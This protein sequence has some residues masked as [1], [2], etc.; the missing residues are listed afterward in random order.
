MR[1]NLPGGKFT[2]SVLLV[3]SIFRV[4]SDQSI[5]IPNN[6]CLLRHG[7]NQLKYQEVASNV[8]TDRTQPHCH[9]SLRFLRGLLQCFGCLELL[10]FYVQVRLYWVKNYNRISD[11]TIKS[12]ISYLFHSKLLF[13]IWYDINDKP[14]I[15]GGTKSS[16]P[17]FKLFLD[18]FL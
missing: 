4:V 2:L 17:N 1:V 7:D 5:T 11:K 6:K 16:W 10:L 13:K 12:N 8:Q 9:S 14:Y 15:V 18:D 3:S